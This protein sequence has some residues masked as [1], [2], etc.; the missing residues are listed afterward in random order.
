MVLTSIVSFIPFIFTI[1]LHLKPSLYFN[2]AIILITIL[3]IFRHRENVKR[4][5]NKNERKITWM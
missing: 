4:I 3:L 2:L 1:M 5:I